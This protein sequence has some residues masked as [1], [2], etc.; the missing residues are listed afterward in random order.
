[1]SIRAF[2]FLL[3]FPL[4]SISQ[5]LKGAV[6]DKV[7]QEPLETAAVYF[8][9]TTIGTTTNEK[10]QFSITYTDAVQ[11]TL[12]ISFLGYEKVFISDYRSRTDITLELVEASNTLDEVYLEYDDGLTRKQKLRLFRAEFLG[13]SKF[14]KSCKILNEEDL[15]LRYN[16]RNKLLFANAKVPVRVK[17]KALKY[18]VTFDIID[19]EVNFNYV[20]PKTNQFS[21]YSVTYTGTSFFKNLDD[22]PGKSALK[23][24]EIAYDGSVQ[25]FMRAL[26]NKNLNDQGYWIFYDKFRVNEWSYFNVETLEDS[27]FKKVTLSSKVSIL[28]KK[29][30]QSEM[31]LRID[32]FFVDIYGN[33]LPILG[34]YFSGAMG[35][36]RVGD[37]LPSDYGI[38][39]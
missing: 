1:M 28:Y 20:N 9:N 22:S 12:V 21:V 36:Q 15:I 2:L 29:E 13:S 38:K 27:N 32:E 11:S 37:I 3:L 30:V 7:T 33:Y 18:E 34:V 8:D 17:N 25:H 23:N 31:E 24:R 16:K 6:I 39:N 5:T 35:S 26:Y 4:Y 10:G 14:A 19:F